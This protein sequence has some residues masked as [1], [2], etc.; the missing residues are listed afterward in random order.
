MARR[1]TNGTLTVFE[2]SEILDGTTAGGA[3][4]MCLDG[5]SA[6]QVAWLG[7]WGLYWEATSEEV[8]FTAPGRFVCVGSHVAPYG[9]WFRPPRNAPQAELDAYQERVRRA[10]PGFRCSCGESGILCQR[11]LRRG[12]VA[13]AQYHSEQAPTLHLCDRCKGDLQHEEASA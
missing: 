5:P 8:S 13:P 6:G 2:C 10:L 7:S 11:C 9:I 1:T 4:F 12:E 3:R